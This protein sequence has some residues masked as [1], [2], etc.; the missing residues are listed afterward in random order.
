MNAG[1]EV[2]S[3]VGTAI[4]NSRGA[5]VEWHGPAS[6]EWSWH[7]QARTSNAKSTLLVKVPRWDGIAT[8]DEALAEG[9]QAA[10]AAEYSALEEIRR[11]V[12]AA[13]DPGLTAVAPVAYVP[14]VNAI[15][16]EQLE[17]TPL[18][19][20][21]GIG[22][23]PADA[24]ELFGRIGRWLGMYHRLGGGEPSRFSA[25]AE[26]ARWDSLGSERLRGPVN[27]AHRV[28]QSLDGRTVVA[29]TQHGDLTLGNVLVTGNGSIAVID[30]NRTP[31][32]WEADAAQLIAETRLG[33]GQLL[34]LGVL[35][36]T[37]VVDRW[38]DAL[39]DGHGGLD[40]EVF[41]YDR[42]AAALERM[43]ALMVGGPASRLTV[44]AASRLFQ[45]EFRQ[46][47]AA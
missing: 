28:A 21:L 39:A 3:A 13:N 22:R 12:T 44:T 24:V 33:R 9:P 7:F 4:A 34:S 17:A 25:A 14:A 16:M 31:G 5:I 23:G 26:I 15:V 46:R 37:A 18:R 36:S 10:T 29:G 27:S 8:L 19:T 6:R 38:A 40:A 11:V 47:F 32:R 41:A 20:R 43:I 1:D 35:R 30:P 45:G 2:R 42:G